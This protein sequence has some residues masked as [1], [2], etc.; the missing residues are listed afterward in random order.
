MKQL[1]F[2][3]SVLEKLIKDDTA[4]IPS[5]YKSTEEVQIVEGRIAGYKK[6]IEAIELI[7]E[8]KL[9]KEVIVMMDNALEHYAACEER[10]RAEVKENPENFGADDAVSYYME[11]A[12]IL[13]ECKQS[14][15]TMIPK[16]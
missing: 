2:L 10:N 13:N 12:S 5:P 1:K 9:Y 11:A 15:L 3:K 14:I 4:T 7:E 16:Q 8:G 6:G